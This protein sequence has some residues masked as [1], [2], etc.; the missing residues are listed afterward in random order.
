MD[1]IPTGTKW[2]VLIDPFKGV[3][4]YNSPQEAELHQEL[5]PT[6]LLKTFDSRDQVNIYLDGVVDAS[7]TF[8]KAMQ[9]RLSNKTAQQPVSS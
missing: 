2:Y 5:V 3:K 6:C 7:L 8:S 9:E 4:V 1:S